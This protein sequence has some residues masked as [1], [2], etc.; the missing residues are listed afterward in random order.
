MDDSEKKDEILAF[1][2]IEDNRDGF[3]QPS[4]L[5]ELVFKESPLT[6]AD[7]RYLVE[8]IIKDGY[9][10]GNVYAFKYDSSLTPFLEAGGYIGKDARK[11]KDEELQEVIFQKTKWEGKIAKWQVIFFWII[12]PI[13]LVGS[14]L[15]L[16]A[17][18]RK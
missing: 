10:N 4:F 3:F 11:K 14:I 9:L 7:L 12:S 16:I 15:G 2:N 6:D 17:F 1:L 5:N 8:S 13:T 18:F